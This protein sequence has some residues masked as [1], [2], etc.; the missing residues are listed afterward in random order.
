M[1]TPA[2]AEEGAGAGS[3]AR[4]TDRISI[5]LLI[6]V[7]GFDAVGKGFTEKTHTL[8]V[9]RHGAKILLTRTLVPE[10]ELSLRCIATGKE[11]DIRVVGQIGSSKEGFHYGVEILDPEVDLWEMVFP[12]LSEADKAAARLL[13]ECARCHARE[14]T[15][16]NEFDLE[17]FQANGTLSRMCKRCTDMSIWK[18]CMA[19]S[20]LDLPPPPVPTPSD[21]P[22]RTQNERKEGRV[23]LKM[24][25]C[26]RHPQQGEE[27]VK[28]LNVSRSGF[29]FKSAK[30][31]EPGIVVQVAVPYTRG[32]GN[33]FTAAKIEHAEPLANEAIVIYGAS[34][35]R[36]S[37]DLYASQDRLRS[38]D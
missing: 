33:I 9:T 21:A 29:C 34:Y 14:L 25:A 7:S 17:V 18:Q 35:V 27:I 4:R 1:A 37:K 5:Q 16:L 13:L 12:P 36:N 22:V 3:P 20:T 31:Y 38:Q 30:T 19:G 26:I 32:V 15:Y 23:A 28:T 10:Q 2:T 11:T 8:V 6:E 24:E